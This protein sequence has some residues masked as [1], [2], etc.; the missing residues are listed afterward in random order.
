M[1]NIIVIIAVIIFFWQCTSTDTTEK[2]YDFNPPAEGFNIDESDS[3]AIAIADSVMKAM[4]GRE[5]WNNTHFISW[6]FFGARKHYWDRFTNDIRIESLHN[7]F[8]ALIN[9][10]D[11]TGRIQKDGQEVTEPDS[12]R[13]YIERAKNFWNNDAYWLIMPYK[14]KDSGV[15]LTYVGEDSIQNAGDAYKLQLTFDNVGTTPNN[16]YHVWADKNSYL[17]RRWAYFKDASQDTANIITPWNEYRKYGDI[18]LSG[19]RGERQ[20]T[21][22]MVSDSLPTAVFESFDPVAQDQ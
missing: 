10:D 7:D 20:I 5:A 1:K 13:F 18:L 3:F 9:L 17:V 2:N 16:K 19:D 15:T 8:V 4:G 11:L 6:N 12:L 21:E 22:I 14:L